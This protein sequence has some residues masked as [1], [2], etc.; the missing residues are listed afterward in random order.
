MPES[1]ST[2]NNTFIWTYHKTKTNSVSGTNQITEIFQKSIEEVLIKWHLDKFEMIMPIVE[3]S[4]SNVYKFFLSSLP[5]RVLLEMG[6]DAVLLSLFCKCIQ[7][8]LQVC[9]WF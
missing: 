4:P 2:N 9:F 7:N 1:N 5:K 8:R 6:D 3:R